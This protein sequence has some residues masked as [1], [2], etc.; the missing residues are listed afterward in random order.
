MKCILSSLL[1]LVLVQPAT[2]QRKFNKVGGGPLE[3]ITVRVEG[4]SFDLGSDTGATD[5][6]PNH[7]VKLN[8]Y[9]ISA[10]E[11][12]QAQW[13][14]IMGDNPSLYDCSDCPVTNVS[15]DDVQKFIEK[16]N[17]L[18]GKHYRLP[19]EAEWEYAA[20]GGTHENLVVNSQ[21][22]ARG[23][24]NRLLT[25]EEHY[26]V[27]EKMKEGKKYSGK[28]GIQPVAWYAGNSKDHIH[29]V[30][31]KQSNELGIYDMSGNV[32]EWCSDFYAKNYGSKNAV[33]NP[34][35]PAGGTA[36]VARGGSW[37]SSAD[38]TVVTYRAGY[39]PDTRS[40]TVGFRLVE[41]K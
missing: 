16:A 18:T 38:E 35:G 12:T 3:V 39:L 24:V 31:H 5:R 40:Y 21:S 8:D 9:N 7:T 20:R 10:Y 1:V 17:T 13:K 19:T 37:N 15:W 11:V 34:K 23:G 22:V 6:R 26:R 29:P 41:D 27:P 4:G 25:S 14:A 33:E 30:G 2:A 36:H 32:E 28:N